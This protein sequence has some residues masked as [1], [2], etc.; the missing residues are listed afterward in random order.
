[1]AKLSPYETGELTDSIF[2]IL[3]A[4][5]PIHGY[6]IMKIVQE[7]TEQSIDIGPATM[8]TTLKKLNQ[9]GWIYEVG[10]EDSKI[11]YKITEGGLKILNENF[12]R[13]KRIVCF[14]EKVMG[15][16]DNGKKS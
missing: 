10:E 5:T 14:A 16:S 13:R 11:L 15:G 6:R 4:T 3:L 8:Y 9:A 12:E 1:V 2:F 7:T